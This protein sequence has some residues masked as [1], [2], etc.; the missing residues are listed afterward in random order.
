MNCSELSFRWH[1]AADG[2]VAVPEIP[3][4]GKQE[5]EVHDREDAAADEERAP[6]DKEGLELLVVQHVGKKLCEGNLDPA[7]PSYPLLC[8]LLFLPPLWLLLLVLPLVLSV[9]HGLFLH[10]LVL[11]RDQILM[12]TALT[13][14]VGLTHFTVQF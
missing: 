5:G 3:L 12:L 8:G 2:K 10:A 6:E 7:N 11:V 14:R 9:P 1:V 4:K 13:L